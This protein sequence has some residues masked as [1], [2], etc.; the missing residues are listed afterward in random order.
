MLL[1]S[2]SLQ[3]KSEIL[4]QNSSNKLF[5]LVILGLWY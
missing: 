1:P 4:L 5:C 3:N 2:E